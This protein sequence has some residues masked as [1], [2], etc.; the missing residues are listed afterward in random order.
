ML[1]RICFNVCM[2]DYTFS[3]LY[4]WDCFL[5]IK[6]ESFHWK[7]LEFWIYAPEKK[8]R[9]WGN[10]KSTSKTSSEHHFSPLKITLNQTREIILCTWKRKTWEFSTQIDVKSEKLLN[11]CSWNRF[12]PVHKKEIISVKKIKCVKSYTK[13][14]KVWKPKFTREKDQKQAKMEFHAHFFFTTKSKQIPGCSFLLRTCF[15]YV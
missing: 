12:F 15:Y 6:K 2:C 4:F 3:Y 5:R 1:I 10:S 9:P 7:F 11:L 13:S 14:K 8:L